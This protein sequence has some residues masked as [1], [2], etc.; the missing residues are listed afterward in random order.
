MLFEPSSLL[1]ISVY[2][3]NKNVK[4]FKWVLRAEFGAEL[5]RCEPGVHRSLLERLKNKT[6]FVPIPPMT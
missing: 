5:A 4:I 3:Q 1:H 6:Y 2:I